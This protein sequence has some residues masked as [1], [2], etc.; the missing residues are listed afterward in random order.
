MTLESRIPCSSPSSFQASASVTRQHSSRTTG[1]L[2]F[3]C[4]DYLLLALYHAEIVL[5]FIFHTSSYHK[6]NINRVN[7]LIVLQLLVKHLYLFWH[8]SDHQ[9]YMALLPSVLTGM[10]NFQV[11]TADSILLN[12][13]SISVLEYCFQKLHNCS[14]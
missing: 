2:L 6:K 8:I 11:N 14:E 4:S 12:S 9:K 1:S 5:S 3:L 10:L 13:K 7:Y